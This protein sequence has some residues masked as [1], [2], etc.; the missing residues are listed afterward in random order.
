MAYAPYRQRL[1]RIQL[2]LKPVPITAQLVEKWPGEAVV[3]VERLILGLRTRVV[4]S[5]PPISRK[6]GLPLFRTGCSV[7]LSTGVWA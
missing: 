5:L 4:P 1:R 6:E 7:G 3:Q 2:I